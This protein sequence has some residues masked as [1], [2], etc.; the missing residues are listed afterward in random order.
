MYHRAK[1]KRSGVTMKNV[2]KILEPFLLRAFIAT[3]A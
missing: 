2:A 3:A 1:N